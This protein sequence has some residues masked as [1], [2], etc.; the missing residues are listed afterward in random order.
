MQ[1]L[2]NDDR[3]GMRNM[4]IQTL[5]LQK[6]PKNLLQGAQDKKVSERYNNS[7]NWKTRTAPRRGKEER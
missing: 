4:G 6:T 5:V 2:D 1:N 7:L 3:T